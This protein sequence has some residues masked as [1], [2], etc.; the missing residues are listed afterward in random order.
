MYFLN[1]LSI[2]YKQI[3]LHAKIYEEI[4][5]QDVEMSTKLGK[6]FQAL[7]IPT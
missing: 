6:L 5:M 7:D 2:L 1:Y 3:Y 4:M